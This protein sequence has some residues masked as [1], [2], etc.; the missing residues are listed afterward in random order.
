MSDHWLCPDRSVA[1]RTAGEAFGLLKTLPGSDEVAYAVLYTLD[2]VPIGAVIPGR[3]PGRKTDRVGADLAAI[4]RRLEAD[5]IDR[6]RRSVAK[7]ERLRFES[8]RCWGP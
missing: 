5:G 7:L 1:S 2:G 4:I 6:Y 8:V 3:W